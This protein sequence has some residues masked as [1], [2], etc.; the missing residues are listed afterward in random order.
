MKPTAKE[1]ICDKCGGEV[2]QR[3]DDKEDVIRKRLSVFHEQ[4][5]PLVAYYKEKGLLFPID[6]TGPKDSVM[7]LLE[8]RKREV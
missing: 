2:V 4:T 1:G 8:E 5:S 6:A 7:K 3:D